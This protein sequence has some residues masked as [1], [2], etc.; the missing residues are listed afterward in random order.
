MLERRLDSLGL[1]PRS[2]LVFT[3]GDGHGEKRRATGAAG[4]AEDPFNKRKPGRDVAGK[5]HTLLSEGILA[6]SSGKGNEYFGGDSTVFEAAVDD[7]EGGQLPSRLP[8]ALP[9]SLPSF[10][11]C[12]PT[13]LPPYLTTLRP[14]Y[15]PRSLHALPPF[16]FAAASLC[17]WLFLVCVCFTGQE[18]IAADG[19][20]EDAN[21]GLGFSKEDLEGQRELSE[22]DGEAD[23]DVD[24]EVEGMGT[25]EAGERDEAEA[26]QAKEA[27]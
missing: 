26:Q 3:L 20:G 2:A 16:P 27:K 7:Q 8:V 22:T 15:L 25:D 14:T 4:Q 9:P 1:A 19:G 24:G 17:L 13:C 18:D 11:A 10:P 12:L 21:R 6:G 23:Y 5:V